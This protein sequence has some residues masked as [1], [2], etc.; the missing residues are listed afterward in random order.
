MATLKACQL[1]LLLLAYLSSALS[2]QQHVFLQPIEF[3]SHYCP[4]KGS[5]LKMVAFPWGRN[6]KG[7]TSRTRG[8]QASKELF[9]LLKGP[10]TFSSGPRADELINELASLNVPFDSGL[11]SGP[12]GVLYATKTDWQK[13][14]EPL[15]GVIPENKFYQEFNVDSGEFSN[16]AELWG[17][18]LFVK[19]NGSFQALGGSGGG[20]AASSTTNKDNNCPYQ[21][22][23]TV[24]GAFL[25][26]G[27][28]KIQLPIKGKGMVN[29][30]YADKNLRIFQNENGGIAVQAPL[31]TTS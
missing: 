26:F 3:G 31:S 20:A 18:S 9:E 13:Y 16:Y 27:G 5:S 10:N 24:D 11:I 8:Q 22:A 7:K 4:A 29:V 30:L 25:S 28:R 15:K 21:I 14:F 2:F 17:E 12:W 23:A 19:T 1:L 6:A